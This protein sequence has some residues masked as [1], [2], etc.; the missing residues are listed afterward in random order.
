MRFL[1]TADWH[2]GRGFARFSAEQRRQLHEGRM[3]SLRRLFEYARQRKIELVLVAGDQIDSGDTASDGVVREMLGLIGGYPEMRVVMIAGNHDPAAPLGIF[4]RLDPA[5]LPEQLELV[6]DGD[7]LELGEEAVLYAASLQ[8]KSGSD[9]PLHWIPARE[10]DGRIRIGL[11]HGSL[12]I[13][14]RHKSDD[15]PIPPGFAE[16]AQL[17]YLALGHWH[18]QYIHDDRT[19]YPGTHEPMGFGERSGALE[20]EIS[21]AGVLPSVTPVELPPHFSWRSEERRFDGEL[22][23]ETIELLRSNAP[24]EILRLELGGELDPEARERLDAALDLGRHSRFAL[25]LEDGCRIAGSTAGLAEVEG[26]GYLSRVIRRVEAG[27]VEIGSSHPEG[28]E[29]SEEEVRDAALRRVYRFLRG[30]G[31]R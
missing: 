17:D 4:N 21:A 8:A 16:D 14:G 24:R 18:S 30:E 3:E 23:G 20:V 25:F 22:P 28:I 31:L 9:N 26:I 7:T 10:G 15:F 13:P 5:L 27:E 12:A 2:L 29:I 11:G 6:G 1:H 19:A